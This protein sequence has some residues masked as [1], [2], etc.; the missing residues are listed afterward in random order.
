MAFSIGVLFFFIGAQSRFLSAGRETFARFV[1]GRRSRRH[2][3]GSILSRLQGEFRIN[4]C[5][6]AA[7]TM[8]KVYISIK[9]SAGKFLWIQSSSNVLGGFL[10]VCKMT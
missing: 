8:E 10:S 4:V 9:M 7:A 3:E 1:L 5:S 6:G 2:K